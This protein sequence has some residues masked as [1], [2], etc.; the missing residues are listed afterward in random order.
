MIGPNIKARDSHDEPGLE[1]LNDKL[2]PRRQ[3]PGLR[4]RYGEERGFRDMDVDEEP[5][6]WA[7]P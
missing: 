6:G 2:D 5:E 4:A 1:N 7:K 3:D